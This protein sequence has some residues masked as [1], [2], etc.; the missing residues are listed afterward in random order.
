MYW[1]QWEICDIFCKC[2]T[3]CPCRTSPEALQA[4]YDADRARTE[5]ENKANSMRGETMDKVTE[6]LENLVTE[7]VND[8]G[9]SYQEALKRVQDALT[10]IS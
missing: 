5:A 4:L 10:A 3:N 1:T 2:A 7:I 9:V 8:D 6:A